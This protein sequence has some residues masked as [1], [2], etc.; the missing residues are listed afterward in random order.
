MLHSAYLGHS[1]SF[2][3]YIAFLIILQITYIMQLIPHH[4]W[5]HTKLHTVSNTFCQSYSFIPSEALFR[6]PSSFIPYVTLVDYSPS[7]LPY[8]IKDYNPWLNSKFQ[9]I[10]KIF[11]LYLVFVPFATLLCHP[12]NI[13]PY[14]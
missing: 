3:P 5:S 11:H 14:I 1:Y 13:T 10:C 12:P 9:T 4:F 2:M 7:V 6:H 8:V